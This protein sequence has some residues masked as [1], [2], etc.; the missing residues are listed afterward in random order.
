VFW[1]I[2]LIKFK[3]VVPVHTRLFGVMNLVISALSC[4]VELLCHLVSAMYFRV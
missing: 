2:H 4:V 3:T 1:R